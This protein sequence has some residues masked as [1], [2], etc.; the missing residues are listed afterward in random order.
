MKDAVMKN[1]AVIH[2]TFVIERSYTA[3]P[4]EVF[5]ALSNPGKRRRWLLEGQNHGVESFEMDFRVGGHERGVL[6]FGPDTPFP[7]TLFSR[8]G[9]FRNIVENER[10]VSACGTELLAIKPVSVSLETFELLPTE[11]ARHRI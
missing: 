3:T 9:D 7:G 8:D 4:A 6:R 10:I 5:A 1:Q 2:N 11:K